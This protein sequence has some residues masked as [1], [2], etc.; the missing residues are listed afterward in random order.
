MRAAI[1]LFPTSEASNSNIAASLPL[2]KR[3]TCPDMIPPFRSDNSATNNRMQKT[4]FTNRLKEGG[5]RL[6]R[7]AA[8]QGLFNDPNPSPPL[9][10]NA[11]PLPRDWPWLRAL[12]NR[13][14]CATLI[15]I[16][17][18]LVYRAVWLTSWYWPYRL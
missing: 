11:E 18:F 6:R 7:F 3:R 13:A 16:G 14:I 17:L 2:R 4:M 1:L 8:W 12:R 5:Q 9:S 15:L 10:T